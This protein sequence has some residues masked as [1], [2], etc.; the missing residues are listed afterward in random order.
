MD[1]KQAK[2]MHQFHLRAARAYEALAKDKTVHAKERQR[3]QE[4]AQSALM[5][6][7][8]CQAVMQVER[9]TA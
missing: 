8:E 9:M 2:G 1:A 3:C 6:A 4:N 5:R 7:A